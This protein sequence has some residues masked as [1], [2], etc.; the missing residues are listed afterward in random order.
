MKRLFAM[1]FGALGIGDSSLRAESSR[2]TAAPDLGSTVMSL[3]CVDR[4]A[5]PKG[6]AFSCSD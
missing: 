3:L 1:N 4:S 6:L 5:R 2:D